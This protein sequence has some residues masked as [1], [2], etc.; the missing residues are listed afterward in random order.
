MEHEKFLNLY[1][2]HLLFLKPVIICMIISARKSLTLQSIDLASYSHQ[3]TIINL[4][5]ESLS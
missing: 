4:R 1:P 2:N 3:L 5:E